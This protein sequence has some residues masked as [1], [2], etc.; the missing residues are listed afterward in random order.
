MKNESG[1]TEAILTWSV[2]TDSWRPPKKIVLPPI[3]FSLLLLAL[4][5]FSLLVLLSILSKVQTI[6]YLKATG[7][8]DHG[9]REEGGRS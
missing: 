8:P 7:D 2:R 3:L 9:F 5:H 4:C 1:E 6:L